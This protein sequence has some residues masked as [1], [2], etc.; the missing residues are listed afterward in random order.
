MLNF[1]RLDDEQRKAVT[2]PDGI[3]RIMAGAGTGKTTTLE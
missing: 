1:E 2:A 3:V